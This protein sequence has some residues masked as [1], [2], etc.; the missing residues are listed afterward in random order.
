MTA[1][2]IL[3]SFPLTNSECALIFRRIILLF[4]LIGPDDRIFHLFDPKIQNY[5]KNTGLKIIPLTKPADTDVFCREPE[6]L[7]VE[8][9]SG[10]IVFSHSGQNYL[11]QLI[12][13]MRNACS[14]AQIR[15]VTKNSREYI[16]FKARDS[17]QKKVKLLA[18]IQREQFE[19]FWDAVIQTIKL[20]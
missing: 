7:I 8:Y 11:R 9:T 20:K 13:H 2:K 4:E 12:R 17:N 15:V 16:E 6:K 10:F 19:K 1:D 3:N 14:H 5:C 18:L